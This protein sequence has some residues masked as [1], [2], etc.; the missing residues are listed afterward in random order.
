[1]KSPE[2]SVPIESKYGFAGRLTAEFPSQ[3]IVDAGDLCNLAC[4]HCPQSL[5]S[6]TPQKA[7]E[8]LDPEMNVKLVDEV[9][10]D[11]SGFV[12]FIRYSSSGETLLHPKIYEMIGY[13]VRHSCTS[14]CVTTNGT[15]LTGRNRTRLLEMGI[16]SIDISLDAYKEETYSKIRVKGDLRVTRKNVLDLIRE[17]RSNGD[18]TRIAVSFIEQP[19][20]DGEA[21]EFEKFWKSQGADFVIIRRLHSNAGALKELADEIRQRPSNVKRRPCLYPWERMVLSSGGYL[22][23]CPADWNHG[24]SVVDFRTATIVETWRG[25]FY[26]RLRRAHLNN[27]Y[28]DFAFCGNCPDWSATRWPGKGRSFAD[29]IQDFAAHP[30]GGKI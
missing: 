17:N 27:D 26:K 16:H 1:M 25:E 19:L 9:G 12:Q 13:A 30:T 24:S 4:V 29:M 22:M 15:L 6:R 8:Y 21:A 28:S 18:K 23:F 11:G 20:N 10:G 7:H 2:G 5:F 14:V 3:L